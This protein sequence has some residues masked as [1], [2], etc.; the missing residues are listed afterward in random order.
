MQ[1]DETTAGIGAQHPLQR[2]MA[3][4][5]RLEAEGDFKGAWDRY[6]TILRSH[7]GHPGVLNRLGFI[8]AKKSDFPSAALYF[9]A[10]VKS[11]PKVP[12]LRRNLGLAYLQA[13]DFE[14]ALVQLKKAIALNPN[15]IESLQGLGECRL[16]L[17]SPD[18]A[19]KIVNKL[20]RLEPGHGGGLLLKARAYQS[21]GQM[22]D[23]AS[24]YR[25][26]IDRGTEL[27]AAYDGLA[28]ARRYDREA[29]E[30][31]DIEA[32]LKQDG[33]DDRDR[34]QLHFAAGKIADDCGQYDRAYTHFV[35]GKNHYGNRFD[36]GAY[37]EFVHG[38]TEIVTPSFVEER[39]GFASR[40]HRPI[41]IF[42]M[43]RSGSTLIDQIIA[44]HPKASSGG[45]VPYFQR[46]MREFGFDPR[47]PDFFL[48]NLLSISRRD[49]SILAD[50]YLAE[51][52]RISRLADRVTDKT[53]HN[54][55][56]L[57]LISLLFPDATYIHSTRNSIANCFSCFASPLG[58]YHSYSADLDTLGRYYR[59]QHR[60]IRH[61]QETLPIEI[62]ASRYEDL[63]G[64]PEEQARRLVSH[65]GLEWD[66]ACLDLDKMVGSV[67][68]LSSWQVRQPLH[69]TSL[70]RW[71]HYDSHL[72]LLKD[73]LGDL[74][75][76]C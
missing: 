64:N 8:A 3:V 54:F 72:G 12:S 67:R 47:T 75:H 39:K 15:S 26:L 44:A 58:E 76:N 30:L 27:G 19:V 38:L 7:P 25:S 62:M 60:L 50:E 52:R 71:K 14:N 57:W 9:S 17:G 29:P 32:T 33:L 42:G 4:A 41:F 66:K 61:W 20:L 24:I 65:A 43:P 10:A 18:E 49:A 68:T 22:E 13:E 31:A 6:Q 5:S 46:V 34:Y 63:V 74:Q 69:A 16:R 51:L 59:L 35:S 37:A 70:E 21:L 45:E 40:T 48:K 2:E 56:H 11:A 28:R 36:L 55:E 53:P 23:A 1:N 73:A